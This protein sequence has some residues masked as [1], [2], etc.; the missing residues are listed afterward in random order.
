M[1]Q[2]IVDITSGLH[3][4]FNV[5]YA[6]GIHCIHALINLSNCN[7]VCVLFQRIKSAR[8][9]Q[10]LL[11]LLFLIIKTAILRKL[12]LS[13]LVQTVPIIIHHAASAFE[14][15]TSIDLYTSL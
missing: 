6:Q 1:L 11:L 3:V 10:L 7:Y 5:H 4:P 13:S 15:G 9:Q 2:C 12:R 14:P 8:S